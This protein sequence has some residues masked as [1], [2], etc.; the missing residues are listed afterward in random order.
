MP[1]QVQVPAAQPVI[2]AA[3]A[4]AMPTPPGAVP[5][6]MSAAAG[7]L[8]T[9]HMAAPVG[10]NLNSVQDFVQNTAMASDPGLLGQSQ[11]VYI[12]QKFDLV[13]ACGIEA[14]N[15][16]DVRIND[17]SGMQTM[18]IREESAACERICCG[19]NRHLVLYVH[20][21]HDKLGT[22][23][24]QIHRSFG[25]PNCCCI[26]PKLVVTDGQGV[27]IGR[28][29]DP[30]KCCDMDQIVYDKDGN[31]VYG[32]AGSICQIGMC[33][34]CC[35]EVKFDVTNPADQ[36]VGSINKIF[37]GC[38]EVMTGCN[39]FQCVFPTDAN[40]QQKMVLLGATMGLDMSYFEKSKNNN[41]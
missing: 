39:Q 9:A 16:Y 7:G 15:K 19:P 1:F 26:R 25:L 14:K 3:V 41:H 27:E 5:T 8:G 18:F 24:G 2:M 37:G 36:E 33:C 6:P 21:G 35:G 28:I 34:P 31:K 20:Q 10:Q 11:G 23:I 17:E 30:F 32:V 40:P 13:E 38:A 22:V 12:R 29:D 4:V